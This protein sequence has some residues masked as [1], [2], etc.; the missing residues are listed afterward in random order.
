MFM[1]FLRLRKGSDLP[2]HTVGKPRPEPRTSM[3]STS[4]STPCSL[5]DGIHVFVFANPSARLRSKMAKEDMRQQAMVTLSP[6]LSWKGK[7]RDR[8]IV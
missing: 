2:R 5:L 1:F 8:H 4:L 7:V 6:S 3:P